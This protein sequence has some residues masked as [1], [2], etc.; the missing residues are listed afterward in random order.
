MRRKTKWLT[1]RSRV[2]GSKA[3]EADPEFAEGPNGLGTILHE[4]GHLDEAL[5]SYRQALAIHPA[6]YPEAPNNLGLALYDQGLLDE[7]AASCRD[8]LARRSD[9]AEAHS[10]YVLVLSK[11]GRLEEAASRCR[12]APPV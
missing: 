12:A 1:S 2:I 4:Q 5:A 6:D 11:Q 10:N 9:Y 3:V 8:A 7:A